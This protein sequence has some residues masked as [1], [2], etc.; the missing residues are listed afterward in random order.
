MSALERLTAYLCSNPGSEH[1]DEEYAAFAARLL[2]Q[3]AH[4]LAE[5][6]RASHPKPPVGFTWSEPYRLGLDDSRRSAAN[7]IDPEVE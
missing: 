2:D 7:L 3:H 5:K 6:I 1:M 4:E